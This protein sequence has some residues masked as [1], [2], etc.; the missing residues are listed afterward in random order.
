MKSS[1]ISSLFGGKGTDFL[2]IKQGLVKTWNP[3]GTNEVEVS[4]ESLFNLPYLSTS[5]SSISDGD[6]VA[7]MVQGA[8]YC[9]LGK[10]INP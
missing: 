4:G 1:N 5:G 10:I 7:V 3:D 9:I 2:R 8:T 6:I